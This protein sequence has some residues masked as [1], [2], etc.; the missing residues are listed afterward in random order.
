MS[1]A[2]HAPTDRPRGLRHATW[3]SCWQCTAFQLAVLGPQYGMY[4]KHLGGGVLPHIALLPV[5]GAILREG[6]LGLARL[7][8]YLLAW[9]I[10]GRWIENWNFNSTLEC[11]DILGFAVATIRW[12]L[13]MFS[14][15]Y[16]SSDLGGVCLLSY[17]YSVEVIC[18]LSSLPCCTLCRSCISFVYVHLQEMNFLAELPSPHHGHHTLRGYVCTMRYCM[19]KLKP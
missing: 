19:R 16:G 7:L 15:G 10:S 1:C 4:A 2:R 12:F 18:G 14:T 3:R 13:V 9:L 17:F 8:S 6:V 11:H 5:Y